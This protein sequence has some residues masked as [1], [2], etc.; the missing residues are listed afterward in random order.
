MDVRLSLETN[1]WK[2]G[3]ERVERLTWLLYTETANRHLED[4]DV[5][6]STDSP[7]A[8]KAEKIFAEHKARG[9]SIDDSVKVDG[10]V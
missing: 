3:V 9:G 5:L 10:D 1:Q 7:F 4:L 6:F 2:F 8:W